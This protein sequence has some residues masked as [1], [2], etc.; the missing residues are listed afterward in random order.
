M[1]LI[2]STS[3]AAL[4]LVAAPMLAG[5]PSSPGVDGQT[6]AYSSEGFAT[7]SEANGKGLDHAASVFGNNGSGNGADPDPL[8]LEDDHDPNT[9]GGSDGSGD[10]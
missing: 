7:S 10:S 1:K 9:F 4:M 3:A 2:L 6:K 5:Q 8:G